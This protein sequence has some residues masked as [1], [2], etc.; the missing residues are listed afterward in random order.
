MKKVLIIFSLILLKSCNNIDFIYSED[1]IVTNPL[2][3]KTKV[4]VTGE[5]L[6]IIKS[7]VPVIF[8]NSKNEDYTLSI[9]VEEKQTKR[10]VETNQATSNLMY[11]LSFLYSIKL[12]KEDCISYEKIILSSF[13]IIP[14][15]SGYNYGTDASLESKYQLA[16][17]NNLNQFVSLLSSIDINSCQ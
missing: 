3:D 16:V 14:K 7:Y 2:Y 11:E 4:I 8:G 5:D 1:K 6:P 15:S 9:K 10:A 12:N 17:S 13:S